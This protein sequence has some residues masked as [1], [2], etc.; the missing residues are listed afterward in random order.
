MVTFSAMLQPSHCRLWRPYVDLSDS[1]W[2]KECRKTWHNYILIHEVPIILYIWKFLDTKSDQR[3]TASVVFLS[4]PGDLGQITPWSRVHLEKLTTLKLFNKFFAFCGTR[5][6]ITA[7][8]SAPQFS[9]PEPDQPSPC[10]IPLPNY[11]APISVQIFQVASFPL[12]SHQNPI[13]IS[14][15]PVLATCQPPI[16][17]ILIWSPE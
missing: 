11:P 1:N 12:V 16:S 3:L 6:S 5:R 10:R 15:F 17:F 14:S 8:K 7:F 9:Y 2:T 13:C 4:L